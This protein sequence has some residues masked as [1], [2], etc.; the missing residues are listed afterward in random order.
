MDDGLLNKPL[1]NSDSPATNNAD[2]TAQPG[3]EAEIQKKIDEALDS[4]PQDLEKPE[5]L[6]PLPEKPEE[7]KE[8][9]KTIEPEQPLTKKPEGKFK[10][11]FTN[12]GKKILGVGA[13]MILLISGILIGKTVV[14]QRQTVETEAVKGGVKSLNKDTKIVK[15]GNKTYVITSEGKSLIKKG[16]AASKKLAE[17]G[18]TYEDGTTYSDLTDEEKKANVTGET[19]I[20]SVNGRTMYVY[21]VQ[22][23]GT[24]K[25][26]AISIRNDA[27]YDAMRIAASRDELS[28]KE[29]YK[30]ISSVAE[31]NKS[32]SEEVVR[33][34]VYKKYDQGETITVQT[35]VKEK[36]NGGCDRWE[37]KELTADEAWKHISQAFSTSNYTNES[38][39][40]RQV[41]I[42]FCPEDS[43][44]K[45]CN[46]NEVL[47]MDQGTLF[48]YLT[49]SGVLGE[50]LAGLC[51]TIQVDVGIPSDG[52][53]SSSVV[54]N[55]SSLAFNVKCGTKTDNDGG[56]E[57][58]YKCVNLDQNVD[59]I[60]LGDEVTFSCESSFSGYEPVAYFRY[61]SDDGDNWT[62]EGTAHDLTSANPAE[63]SLTIDEYGDW[64]VQCQI[65]TD[66][67][68]E[69]CTEWGQAN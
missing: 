25:K 3:T 63:M 29:K 20:A 41:N 53:K 65:C 22:A 34:A 48:Y 21:K 58:K 35:C 32:V 62:E 67:T 52:L 27:T 38:G 8:E 11:A 16:S 42:Y 7:K 64:I 30:N 24:T 14:Q 13:L 54:K 37:M 44:G 23:D 49:G 5:T 69:T 40:L 12:K 1:N 9:S 51:G 61:S 18:A 4:L 68:Q 66:D 46:Q 17:D 55:D 6:P 26:M 33:Q 59:E 19:T 57:N 39:L 31:F 47:S 56:D 43:N 2:T 50:S 45:V 60:E 36:T 10:Q 15:E 28:I